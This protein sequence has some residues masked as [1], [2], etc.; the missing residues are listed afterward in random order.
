VNVRGDGA[1]NILRLR[2]RGS[3]DHRAI[4]V[5]KASSGQYTVSELPGSFGPAA[6]TPEQGVRRHLHPLRRPRNRKLTALVALRQL[7]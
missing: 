1:V 7:T 2:Y 4:A 6:G 5:C 3:A